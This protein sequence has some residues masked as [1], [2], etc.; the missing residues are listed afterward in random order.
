MSLRWGGSSFFRYVCIVRINFVLWGKVEF[1]TI[2]VKDMSS[3]YLSRD[4]G[5]ICMLIVESLY[6]T[7]ILSGGCKWLD[8]RR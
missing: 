1:E 6:S 7:V 2:R 4:I 3:L 5:L 8:G